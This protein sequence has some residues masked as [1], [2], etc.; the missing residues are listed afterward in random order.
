MGTLP[1]C[2]KNGPDLKR[3][4]PF[5][6]WGALSAAVVEPAV[7]ESA[8]RAQVPAPTDPGSGS[9][10]KCRLARLKLVRILAADRRENL[11]ERNMDG[12]VRRQ[13]CTHAIR[14]QGGYVGVDYLPARGGVARCGR[15]A[16]EDAQRQHRRQ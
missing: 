11:L 10:G 6:L 13:D 5:S 1:I 4:R 15:N 8:V 2:W 7:A 12:V 9:R 14:E 3:V 16:R